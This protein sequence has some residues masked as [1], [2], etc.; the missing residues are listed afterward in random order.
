MENS[1]KTLKF[2][3]Y[4]LLLLL[5]LDLIVAYQLNAS[6]GSHWCWVTQ[7]FN[8]EK[9]VS[10]EGALSVLQFVLFAATLDVFFRRS[11]LQYNRRS[12]SSQFPKILIEI[13][14]V[15]IYGLVGL[16]GFILLYDFSLNALFAASGAIGLGV[17]YGLKD[18]LSN[19]LAS[20]QIQFDKLFGIGDW[21]ELSGDGEPKRL[22]ILEMDHRMVLVQ[23]HDEQV[24]LLPNSKFLDGNVI[25]LS[26]QKRRH[27]RKIKLLIDS[28]HAPD[29][30]IPILELAVQ[31]AHQSNPDI[32]SYHACAVSDLDDGQTGYTVKYECNPALDIEASNGI[33]FNSI[34]RFLMAAS[35]D[36]ESSINVN[37]A[38]AHIDAKVQRLIDIRGH[39]IL[40]ALSLQEIQ[41]LGAKIKVREFEAGDKVVRL[42]D[43]G[44]SMYLIAEGTLEVCVPN[45]SGQLIPVANLWPGD[46]V[47]EMSLL[48]GAPRS[49]DV[50]ALSHGILLEVTKESLGPILEANPKLVDALSKILAERALQNQKHASMASAQDKRDMRKNLSSQITSFFGFVKKII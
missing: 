46:C 22:K 16:T 37:R 18:I 15:L 39:G 43:S 28:Q 40:G 36:L 23:N 1:T 41:T 45:Q 2:L 24:M 48:T 34:L 33:V 13:G 31:H 50:N 14:S 47:G 9:I 19:N 4:G 5:F 11:C 10:F 21:V 42:G 35:I 20:V 44:E 6:F 26:R 3:T 38:T 7:T 29:R 12:S 32:D 8:E 25:N 17:V 49:A 27:R 30:V